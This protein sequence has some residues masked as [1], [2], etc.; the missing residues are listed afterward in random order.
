[1]HA[2]VYV[3]EY[4]K[5]DESINQDLNDITKIA[6]ETNP[7]LS[8]TGLLFYHNRKFLQ[9]IEGEKDSLE[10]LMVS[11]EKDP[12]HR[13]IER[14]IDEKAIRRS[15]EDWNMDSFNLSDHKSLDL[16]KLKII[17]QIYKESWLLESE[18]LIDFYKL[19]LQQDDL[20]KYN[21]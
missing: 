4:T 8:I 1:M 15:Y 10:K 17:N 3:S 14:I 11:I 16:D 21:I 19:K 20:T 6:K 9:I 5:S 12:R 7:T 18:V 13:N 2:I